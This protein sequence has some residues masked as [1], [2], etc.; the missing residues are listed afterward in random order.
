MGLGVGL[1]LGLE[2]GLGS[3]NPSPNPNPDP[4]PHQ[5][6]E[7]LRAHAKRAEPGHD[8]LEYSMRSGLG[9]PGHDL[10][11]VQHVVRAT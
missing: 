2:L 1:G 8:L 9:E 11:G 5:A 7:L 10:L 4:N 6:L 3:A